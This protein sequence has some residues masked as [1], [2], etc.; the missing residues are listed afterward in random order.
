MS[1][2]IFFLALMS[3]IILG[4]Y[5]LLKKFSLKNNPAI[6]VIWLANLCGLIFILPIG[7]LQGIF[8]SP[9]VF[10]SEWH[11]LLFAKAI[12]VSMSWNLAYIGLKHLPI[13]IASPV[14]ASLLITMPCFIRGVLLP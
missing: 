9:G 7:F 12:L 2:S 1:T 10:N 11:G 6:K 14:R 5:D 8:N 13:S 4:L 3:A